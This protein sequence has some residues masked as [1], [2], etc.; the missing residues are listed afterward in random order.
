MN[1][2]VDM[3][4]ENQFDAWQEE[5]RFDQSGDGLEE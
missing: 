1:A 2:M 3:H 5:G 4:Q